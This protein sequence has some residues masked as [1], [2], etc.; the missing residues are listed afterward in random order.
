MN[1]RASVEYKLIDALTSTYLKKT[2]KRFC[3]W[4]TIL[5]EGLS[6]FSDWDMWFETLLCM[7]L[8]LKFEYV[9]VW[10]EF[11]KAKYNSNTN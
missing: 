7:G 10:N 5:W 11:N 8:G 4:L 3:T 2:E 9:F 6:M 1:E